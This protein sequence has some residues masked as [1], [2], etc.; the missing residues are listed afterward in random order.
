METLIHIINHAPIPEYGITVNNILNLETFINA[1]ATNIVFVNVDSYLATGHNYYIY[2]NPV[3]DKFEWITWDVNEAF[4]LWNC[5]MPLEQLYNLHI[6]YLPQNAETDRPLSYYMLQDSI[7]RNMYTDKVY[8]LILNEFN[9]EKLYPKIDYLHNLIKDDV[10]SDTNKILGND[11]FENNIFEDV[12]IQGY[13]GWVPGLKRFIQHRFDL[14]TAQLSELGY[15]FTG[16]SDAMRSVTD[17]SVRLYPNPADDCINIEIRPEN[18]ERIFVEITNANGQ[19]LLK[20]AFTNNFQ[21]IDISG[22]SKGIYL[23]KIISKHFVG[24]EKIIKIL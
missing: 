4:G 21:K 23:V 14:L 1:W 8:D 19:L 22:Y 5:C 9:P 3:N 24:I 7:L 16:I 18:N 6:F 2:H 20:T 17:N 11:H 13:P 10:Y 15:S 12:Y